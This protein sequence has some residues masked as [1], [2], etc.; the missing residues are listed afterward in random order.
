MCLSEWEIRFEELTLIVLKCWNYTLCFVLCF[1]CV[2][3]TL[4]SALFFENDFKM[5]LQNSNTHNQPP[6]LRCSLVQLE[7]VALDL[8]ALFLCI[9]ICT[10]MHKTRLY[11]T[12]IFFQ[13]HSP[14]PFLTAWRRAKT[15]TR[16][17]P[18]LSE[19][20]YVSPLFARWTKFSKQVAWI[21]HHSPE[22]KHHLVPKSF[23]VP[24]LAAQTQLSVA[25]S[26]VTCWTQINIPDIMFCRK[27][28]RVIL[29]EAACLCL[30]FPSVHFMG[31]I[32]KM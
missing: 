30:L 26:G 29:C 10:S 24:P 22:V 23:P 7:V 2:E 8:C 15:S 32:F 20:S 5:L 31:L 25:T 19:S 6:L 3:F 21:T 28:I 4:P 11:F 12:N 14:L 16:P 27:G 1:F 18:L 9:C 17:S 13:P